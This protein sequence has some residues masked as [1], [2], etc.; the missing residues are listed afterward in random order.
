VAATSLSMHTLVGLS[1]EWDEVLL[2]TIQNVVEE[3]GRTVVVLDDDPTGTQTVHGI[4]VLTEWSVESLRAEL[5]GNPPSFYILTNSRSLPLREAQR[6]NAIIGRNLVQASQLS[7]R[8]FVIVSRSDST[9]RGHFPGE[10][11]ALLEALALNV[12]GWLIVPFFLEGGRY[13]IDDVHYVADGDGLTPAGETQY[14]RDPSFGYRQ[15]NLRLWVEEKTRGR[16]SAKSVSSIS[17]DDIRLGGPARVTE[18]LLGLAKG[19]MCAI[20]AVSYRD[21]EVFVLGLLAAEQQGRTYI[22]RT[23]ASFVRVRAGI[24][25]RAFLT[26]AELGASGANG[27][28]FIVGSHVPK[29]TQQV[30]QLL[31]VPTLRA[32][33]VHIPTLLMD[34][35]RSG[36]IARVVEECNEA[37]SQGQDAM[38]YTSRQLITGDSAEKALAIGRKVS[39]GLVDIMDGITVRPRFIVAKGGITASEIATNGLNIKRAM[40]KGQILPG[41]PVW[42]SG[43][44]S[45]FPD[46]PYVV[47]PGNVDDAESLLRIASTLGSSGER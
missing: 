15:S 11:D 34:S 17:L 12:D 20:N 26:R 2:P 31:G 6:L 21:I 8:A 7:G 9:L 30:E 44:E 22:Y 5:D 32:A 1:P 37:I 36:E 33:E 24:A 3:S 43:P 16:V 13:T 25:P 23:A 18:R 28:L 27:G 10:V 42:C 38:I 41:V 19:Q 29:T 39:E 47:F 40:V 14:A 46:M 45:R 4:P 35:K